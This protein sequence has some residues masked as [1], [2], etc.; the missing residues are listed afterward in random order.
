[1]LYKQ[2]VFNI[3]ISRWLLYLINLERIL[4]C[5]PTTDDQ[6]YSKHNFMT[7]YIFY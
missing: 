6:I 3:N 7:I 4:Q 5:I 1:M 2:S